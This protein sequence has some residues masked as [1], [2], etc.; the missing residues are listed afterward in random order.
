MDCGL[1]DDFAGFLV[2][3]NLQPLVSLLDSDEEISGEAIVEPALLQ[4]LADTYVRSLNLANADRTRYLSP[5][6]CPG[7]S[8]L[9]PPQP[10]YVRETCLAGNLRFVEGFNVSIRQNDFDNSLSFDAA[11]GAGAGEPCNEVQVYDGE[12]PPA[13]SLFLTGGPSCS[14]VV[15]SLNGAAGPLLQLAADDGAAIKFDLDRHRV[16]IDVDLHSLAVCG[17]NLFDSEEEERNCIYDILGSGSLQV[18]GV[19]LSAAGDHCGGYVE[20]EVEETFETEG[21]DTWTVPAGVTELNIEC[22]GGGSGGYGSYVWHGAGPVYADVRRGGGGGSGGA[23]AAVTMEVSPGEELAITV[24]AGGKGTTPRAWP[25]D[26]YPS[27]PDNPGGFTRFGTVDRYVQVPGGPGRAFNGTPLGGI[28]GGSP[29]VTHANVL[30][31]VAARGGYGGDSGEGTVDFGGGGGGGVASSSF[32]AEWEAFYGV[33]YDGLHG[34]PG[35]HD[36]DSNSGLGGAYGNDENLR[37]GGQGGRTTAEADDLNGYEGDSPGG[38]G[39]GGGQ[40]G[41]AIGGAGGDGAPGKIRITYLVRELVEDDCS[42]HSL[43]ADLSLPAVGVSGSGIVYGGEAVEMFVDPGTFVWTAPSSIAN[44]EVFVECIGGGAGGGPSRLGTSSAAGAGGGGGAY[45]AK[46]VDVTPETNYSIRVGAGSA[47]GTYA[48]GNA[49]AHTPAGLG[50]DS[51]FDNATNVM[52]KGGRG[53]AA[54]LLTNDFS[55]QG[56]QASESVGDVTRNGGRGR[57]AALFHSGPGGG[58]GGAAGPAS[59][60]GGAAGLPSSGIGH[61]SSS[62]G[63]GGGSPAGNGGAGGLQSNHGNPGQACGGGGGG[64]GS[65]ASVALPTNGGHGSPGCVRLTYTFSGTLEIVETFDASTVWKAPENLIGSELLVECWGGGGGGGAGNLVGPGEIDLVKSAGGGGGGAYEQGMAPV[66]PGESYSIRVGLGG[67]GAEP[68][69]SPG[70]GEDGSDSWFN[71]AGTVSAAGGKGGSLEEP[72]DGGE[73]AFDGGDGGE[74]TSY[75]PGNTHYSGGGGGSS[76]SAMSNGNDGQNGLSG[77]GSSDLG[78]AGGAGGPGMGAGGN[79]LANHGTHGD[80]PGG[81]G[82]GGGR[83]SILAGR[84]GRGGDGRVRITYQI[85]F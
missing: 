17:E 23:Y 5:V 1:A 41:L 83:G 72:G 60:G 4:I 21:E 13:D 77:L 76:A 85:S 39:G 66:T 19:Q 26:P 58:G 48:P 61:F 59:A 24:G 45:A 56:G 35:E 6:G 80:Q 8:W 27:T 43:S 84:G 7:E 46:T 63:A 38:G 31:H 65:S 29:L 69:E 53:G 18:A 49:G 16:T 70:A 14:E 3:G 75:T 51:W 9:N 36:P 52:A 20:F 71:S 11:I 22:W 28:G 57:T 42:V 64:G 34:L 2:T 67:N 78:G 50:G 15:R 68:T 54:A 62:P 47:G 32:Q 10:L 55:G 25:Q 81:G 79:G 74:G 82:G 44:N 73:G 40:I 33:P 37:I 30:L 12:E